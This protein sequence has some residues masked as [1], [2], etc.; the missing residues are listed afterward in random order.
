MA[1]KQKSNIRDLNN[2]RSKHNQL[3]F[4]LAKC[5]NNN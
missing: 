3:T 1:N 5:Q 2:K 4:N